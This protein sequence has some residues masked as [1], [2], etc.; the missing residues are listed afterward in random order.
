MTQPTENVPVL[1][2]TE[3]HSDT[4]NEASNDM[5]MFR[6]WSLL[7]GGAPMRDLTVAERKIV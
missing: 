1:K 6:I 7:T 4:A 5:T 2:L 3:T